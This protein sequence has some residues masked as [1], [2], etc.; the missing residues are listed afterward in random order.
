MYN[1]RNAAFDLKYPTSNLLAILKFAL[2][3][4]VFEIFTKGEKMPKILP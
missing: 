3:L 1:I 4:N 2:S